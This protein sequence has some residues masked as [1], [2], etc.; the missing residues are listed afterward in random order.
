MLFIYSNLQES[1]LL[2]GIDWDAPLSTTG[3]GIPDQVDLQDVPIPLSASD[4]RLLQLTVD[5]IRPSE[6]YGYSEYIETLQF[7]TVRSLLLP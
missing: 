3:A 7:V 6:D 4:F 1:S 5:P 2:Y